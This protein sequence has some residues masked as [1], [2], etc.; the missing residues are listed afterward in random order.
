MSEIPKREQVPY[1]VRLTGRSR[2]ERRCADRYVPVASRRPVW[3][4]TKPMLGNVS[5]APAAFYPTFMIA[6]MAC[7]SSFSA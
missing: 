7:C 1:I 6:S 5:T 2:E 4:R 3:C